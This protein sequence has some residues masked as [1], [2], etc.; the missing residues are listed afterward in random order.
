MQKQSIC[1]SSPGMIDVDVALGLGV[2]RRLRRR[3]V[4]GEQA[5]AQG[6]RADA[7]P[8]QHAPDAVGGDHEAAPLRTGELAGDVRRAVAGVPEGEGDDALLDEHRDRVRHLRAAALAGPQDLEAEALDLR[9]PAVEGRAVD[10]VQAAGRG[11]ASRAPGRWRAPVDG[12]R[13]AHHHWSWG[14]APSVEI[15][16]SDRK[17][18]SPHLNETRALR[19]SVLLGDQRRGVERHRSADDRPRRGHR[20]PGSS[21]RRSAR[22][23]ARR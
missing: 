7:V 2:P 14:D 19:V 1:T 10:A 3:G 17:D 8:A 22:L 20:K 18:A 5:V 9:L 4:A 23:L 11:H 12:R 15:G 6:P 21:P 16:L 13:K